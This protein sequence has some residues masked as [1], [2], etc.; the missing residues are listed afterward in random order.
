MKKI[1]ATPKMGFA[2]NKWC[3]AVLVSL[4]FMVFSVPVFSAE[5]TIS[6]VTLNWE[7]YAGETLQNFG[8]CSEIVKKAFE[9]KGYAVT[10]EFKPWK[11]V[12]HET[13]TGKYDALF[14][15]Y[16]SEERAKTY[17]MS[18][19]FAES[20]LGFFKQ[21]GKDIAYNGL[22]G[23]K[24]YTIG[25][26]LG[27]VNT[28]EFD[29]ADFLKK[30]TS[31]TDEA[32]LKKL[33]AGRV[34]LAVVDK[35]IGAHLMNTTFPEGK[36]SLEFVSTPLALNPLHLCVSKAKEGWEEKLADFNEGLKMIKED[37]TYAAILKA[38]GF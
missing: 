17:G 37:G 22:E 32:S 4:C 3:I 15:A 31:P 36:E 30:E 23:L 33:A 14:L 38:N 2:C 16:Y 24:D 7:P 6:L 20:V 35:Y 21:K 13:E 5:K 12:L 1:I 8:F 10:I 29:E 27:Y 19:P 25:V 28:K 26:T 11:R 9:K 18:D 34:D